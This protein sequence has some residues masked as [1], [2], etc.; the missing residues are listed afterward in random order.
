MFLDIHQTRFVGHVMTKLRI[1]HKLEHIKTSR[2]FSTCTQTKR[3]RVNIIM[4]IDCYV[5]NIILYSNVISD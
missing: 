5:G 3:E 4:L 2:H 1:Q